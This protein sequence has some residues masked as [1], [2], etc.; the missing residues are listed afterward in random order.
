MSTMTMNPEEHEVLMKI[1]EAIEWGEGLTAIE[2]REKLDTL[3]T[4]RHAAEA[5]RQ[6]E[7]E[8]DDRMRPGRVAPR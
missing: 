3:V 4:A 6:T 5:E 8:H 2:C 7:R 1:F